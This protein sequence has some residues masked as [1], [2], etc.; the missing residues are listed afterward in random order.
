MHKRTFCETYEVLAFL[1]KQ[2][3]E[4][5]ATP[6][7][8][9]RGI[10]F[11]LQKLHSTKRFQKAV[12]SCMRGDAYNQETWLR[13]EL[14]FNKLDANQDGRVSREEFKKVGSVGLSLRLHVFVGG[15]GLRL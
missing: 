12:L 15:V 1:G 3:D 7:V 8:F 2:A 14:E 9:D 4:D 10:L 13:F 6:F 11:D 5:L